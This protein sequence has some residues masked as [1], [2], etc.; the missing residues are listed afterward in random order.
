MTMK[1]PFAVAAQYATPAPMAVYSDG[2]SRGTWA[3]EKFYAGFGLTKLDTLDYYTLRIRSSQLFRE[4]LFARGLLRRMITN[5]ISTGLTLDPE[6][7][8]ELLGIEPEALDLWAEKTRSRFEAYA[9]NPRVCDY[10]ERRTLGELQI[11]ARLEALIDGDLLVQLRVDRRTKLPRV[12][13]ISGARVS[14]PLDKFWDKNVTHGVVT[15]DRNRHVGYWVSQSGGTHTYVPAYGARTGRRMAWLLYGTDKRMDEVRGTPLLGLVLQ[16]L[17]ELDKYQDAE[18]RAAVINSM[19]AVWIKKTEDKP[20]TRPFTGGAVRH[21]KFTGT[22]VDGGPREFNHAS[23]IPGMVFEELQTGEE[24]V[25]FDAKRPNLDHAA[26][27]DGIVGGIAWAN[28]VPPEILMLQ[29]GSNYSASKA[30]VQEYR[31]YLMKFRVG[32]GYGFCRWVYLDWLQV[33]LLR[34]SIEAD[35]LLEAWGAPEAY[36]IFGGWTQHTWGGPVKPSIELA[37]DVKAYKDAIGATL[38]YHDRAS[39]DLFG[40]RHSRVVKRLAREAAM[41]KAAG[42]EPEPAEST[43][44]APGNPV[45]PPGKPAASVDPETG[46]TDAALD[47]ITDNVLDIADER[48]RQQRGG[49]SSAA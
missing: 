38:I 33:E 25:S 2:V 4:N 22:Q 11:D 18:I 29:F 36:D 20:A 26:F 39:T 17:N 48:L 47:A 49:T 34:G 31:A 5:E 16:S 15:D 40:V 6:P 9:S 42:I 37:K 46:L 27:R 30:A 21:D 7:N 32:F 1:D 23:T 3:G 19:L 41:R 45:V 10:E 12:Q 43:A 14:T 28:E 44:S 24:P 8:E 35:G 13:L